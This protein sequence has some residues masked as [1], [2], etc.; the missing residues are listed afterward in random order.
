MICLQV[1]PITLGNAMTI[2]EI[3][4]AIREY[5]PPPST[6]EQ[7]YRLNP[8]IRSRFELMLFRE[9]RAKERIN[10]H[11]TERDIIILLESLLMAD[12]KIYIWHRK[13]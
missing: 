2:Q 10:I 3:E 8:T 7:Q 12:P 5:S 9:D 11:L 13:Q 1:F 4:T 6:S